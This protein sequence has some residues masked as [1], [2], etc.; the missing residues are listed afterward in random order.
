[1]NGDVKHRIADLRALIAHH[2]H[3]YY[4]LDDPEI[5]DA[6]YDGLMRELVALE[7]AHPE[8][9]SP[10]S[11]SQRVGGA[12]AGGFTEARHLQPMLS[13]SNAFSPGEFEE[14]DR[15]V[16][17]RLGVAAVVYAA[18]TK[19]DGLAISL[20]YEHGRLV[21]AATRGDGETGEDVTA[22]VRTIRAVPLALR[23]ARP[24][25]LLEVRGEIY[26][27]HAGFRRLNEAQLGKGEK[28]FANPRNAAAGSLR[29]LDPAIT[30]TRPLTMFSY[31]LGVS[32]GLDV[33]D[34]H[35]ECLHLLARL[36]LRISPET[37]L[38]HGLEAA[39]E[40][41]SEIGRRRAGL[42]YDID[43]VVFKV[44][45]RAAQ[46]TLG[47]VARAPR[48]AVAFKFPP[49]E[50]ETKVLAIDVQV[51]RT[52]ALTPVARLAPVVVGGVTVTNAT[53]HNADELRR[54]DIRV[55]DT[56][57][58]RRA[59][60]VIPEIV[61]VVVAE[62]PTGAQPFKM[63]DSVPGQAEA[64]RV[65]SIL[66]FASRRAMDIEGLGEKLVEQ[67]VVNGL[68]NDPSDL[69]EL[70]L[71]EIA[72]QERLGEKSAQNLLRAIDASRTTTLPRLLLSLGIR[73]V[74]EATARQL[75]AHFGTLEALMQ[76]PPVE[77]E[78]VP[79]V[80]P[81][82]ATSIHR[83]F[84]DPGHLALIE[85]LRARG[86]HWPEAP[87]RASEARLPLSGWTV[88][89]TGTLASCTREEAADQLRA[90]G[91][92]VA[93]SVSARTTLVIV[94]ADAGSKAEKAAALGVPLVDEQ[95][96]LRLLADPARAEA[97]IQA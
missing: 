89:L 62:R 63:P 8:Y 39:L 71:D 43:G 64:Q 20:L 28:T 18:E 92:K 73:E 25:A 91:A 16:R 42:S 37:R 77:L 49:E 21:R 65:Q 70:Q 68:V 52:G 30:A 50:K 5:S 95:A 76:A 93:G 47:Q 55:G 88:V 23:A 33:P 67:F 66:H 84:Q 94:G 24:P 38:V 75:V 51:G 69:Y 80:G 72:A 34:S 1:M 48:W 26:L 6:D 7:T 40:Y 74:G 22:N 3:R 53:L 29:Q 27:D 2:D 15:R 4:V 79:D 59:G 85:R 11:P 82:V 45:S 35:I 31:A 83:F 44:D 13:L 81:A 41:Y 58:V 17:S 32:D 61:R 86:V 90:L 60:D 57:M 10:D 54:K 46:E 12:V 36:G 97:L 19:L 87:P 96:L 14:F 78:Q 56:V 9:L